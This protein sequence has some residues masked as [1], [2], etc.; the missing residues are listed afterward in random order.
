MSPL[1]RIDILKFLDAI[2]FLIQRIGERRGKK[3][4]CSVDFFSLS[5]T[6]FP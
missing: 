5:L 4:T 6:M 3:L 2:N 1:E